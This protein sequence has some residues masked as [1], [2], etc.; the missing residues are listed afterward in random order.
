MITRMARRVAP[1]TATPIIAPDDRTSPPDPAPES[2]V[3]FM[4]VE[5]GV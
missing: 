5:S 4:L 3:V 1:P 2:P